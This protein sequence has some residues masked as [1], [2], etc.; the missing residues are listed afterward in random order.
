MKSEFFAGNRTR[1]V[2]KLKGGVIVLSAYTAQQR[3]DDMSFKFEQESNFWYLTGVE[4][5]DWRLIID[6]TRHKSWLVAPSVDA[7]HQV[8]DGSLG[9]DDAKKIS[10]VDEVIDMIAGERLL[11]DLAKRHSVVHTLGES[12]YAKYYDFALNPAQRKLREE[13]NRTFTSVRDCS[14]ELVLLRAIKGPEEI[15]AIKKA[16]K[17]TCDVFSE[18]KSRIETFRSEYE[19]EAEYTYRFRRASADGHAYDPI[20]AAGINACT[21]HYVAN[22]D[23]LRKGQMVL[24]DIGARVG[25]YA[26]DITR[27]Y[28]YGGSPSHRAQDVHMA[29]AEAQRDIIQQI[30]PGMLVEEYQRY[31]DKR[32][33]Q[34]LMVLGLAHSENDIDSLRKYMPHSIGHGL[35]VDVHDQ[36]GMP[37]VFQPGMVMTVEPGIYIPEEKIGVRIEDDILVTSSS[38][39][40]LSAKL[41]TDC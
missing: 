16:V 26:A 12:P 9:W 30:G 18:V 4:N 8:F 19:I 39:Q 14:K 40:N 3:R 13:L 7:V 38:R 15:V 10:G 31:V 24:I 11:G 2:E 23:K 17:L 35:G 20:V 27:T 6:G 5:A 28:V 41:S 22:S 34:A 25:G 33:L 29:V 1:L 32:M 36:L 37:R 21:L